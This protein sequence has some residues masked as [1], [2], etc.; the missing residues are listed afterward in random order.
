MFSTRS[1]EISY[2]VYYD[3]LDKPNLYTKEYPTLASIKKIFYQRKNKYD[4]V[5]LVKETIIYE[6]LDDS[7]LDDINM[8]G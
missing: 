8:K 3:L 7:I 1:P 5:R 2:R 4:N 6:I